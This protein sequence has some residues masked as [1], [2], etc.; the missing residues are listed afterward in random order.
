MAK[1]DPLERYLMRRA[2]QEFELDFAELG[3]IIGADLP[4]S[5][6]RPQWWANETKSE[7]HVQCRAWRNASYEAFLL[8]HRRVLF[9]QRAE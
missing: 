3:R 1:Y 8:P 5:A 4:P 7:A 9:R 2:E 6:T